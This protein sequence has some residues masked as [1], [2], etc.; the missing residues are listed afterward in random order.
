MCYFSYVT[1]VANTTN[2]PEF[3]FFLETQEQLKEDPAAIF[4]A[5]LMN[6]VKNEDLYPLY[7]AKKFCFR[8]PATVLDM[9]YQLENPIYYNYLAND[10]WLASLGGF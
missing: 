9:A 4:I 10:S 6:S 2:V 5:S 8:I 7:F 1:H 3:I